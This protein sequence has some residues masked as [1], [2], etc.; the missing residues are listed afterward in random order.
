MGLISSNDL[1][2][3]G[4][5]PSRALEPRLRESEAAAMLCEGHFHSLP[6]VDA[7]DRLLGIITS[8][9]LIHY[10]HELLSP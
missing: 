8:T 9:D 4:M 6:V 1:W 5:D 10:L 7:D 2:R 3:A